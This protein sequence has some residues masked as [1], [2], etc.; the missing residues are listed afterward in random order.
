MMGCELIPDGYTQSDA[1]FGLNVVFRPMPFSDYDDYMTALIAA[2]PAE[3][4]RLIGEKVAE[5]IES[6]SATLNGEAVP[7]TPENIGRLP[8]AAGQRL[9]NLITG[10]QT[11]DDSDP[12]DDAKN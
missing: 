8:A 11:A 7:V 1:C 12:G 6:W 4:K 2:E 5:R 3:R 9:R 10:Q